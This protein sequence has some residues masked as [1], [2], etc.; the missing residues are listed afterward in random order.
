MLMNESIV[1][2]S[3]KT[4][5]SPLSDLAAARTYLAEKAQMCAAAAK[6]TDPREVW[7]AVAVA[8]N[9]GGERMRRGQ[10]IFALECAHC[11]REVELST[12]LPHLC[13]ACG[14]ELQILWRP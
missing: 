8:E 11:Q 13:P 9:R 1:P 14:R 5:N 3:G 12:I 7:I 2:D 6:S 10:E 4:N